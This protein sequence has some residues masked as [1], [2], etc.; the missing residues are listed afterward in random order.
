MT[1]KYFNNCY[2]KNVFFSV[3]IVIL[4]TFLQENFSDKSSVIHIAGFIYGLPILYFVLLNSICS[5]MNDHLAMKYI[6][7]VFLGSFITLLAIL[8]SIFAL[9]KKW[10]ILKTSVIG[11]IVVILILVIYMKFNIYNY[12]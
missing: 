8:S 3:V 9:K 11:N 10:S 12:L 4:F 2:L 1:Q 7:N 6:S 5:K